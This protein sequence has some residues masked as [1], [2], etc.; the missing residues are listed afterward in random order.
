[1]SDSNAFMMTPKDI[2]A[3]VLVQEHLAHEHLNNMPSI[4]DVGAQKNV[5]SAYLNNKM[6]P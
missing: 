6:L 2:S 1:M 4:V 3:R 5:S